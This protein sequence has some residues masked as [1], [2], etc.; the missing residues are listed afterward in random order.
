MAAR[1][2]LAD[3]IQDVRDLSQAGPSEYAIGD[4]SYF[5]DDVIQRLLD[6]RRRD[7]YRHALVPV[8]DYVPGGSVQ[9]LTYEAKPALR[10]LEATEG[11]TAVFV[12]EDAQ[13]NVVGTADWTADYRRGVVTFT[14][15]QGGT[16]YYLT[17]RTYDVHGAAADVLDQWATHESRAFDVATPEVKASRS[18]K[19][20]MLREAARDLRRQAWVAS[21]DAERGDVW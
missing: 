9:Y 10:Y 17:A 20:K 21:F 16:A 6:S 15:D 3:R 5:S 8:I 2:T 13:G 14:A 4:E 18:Q 11:G 19:A 12:I 1:A 7:V